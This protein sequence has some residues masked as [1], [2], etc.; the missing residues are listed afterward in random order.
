[1][2]IAQLVCLYEHTKNFKI[3]RPLG[4]ISCLFILLY[5]SCIKYNEINIM[6]PRKHITDRI[7]YEYRSYLFYRAAQNNSNTLV[8]NAK[9]CWI[10]ILCYFMQFLNKF[11][12]KS[13]TRCE[14]IINWAIQNWS[15][16]FLPT[17]SFAHVSLHILS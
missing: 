1:M 17:R 11:N 9:C 6:R 13:T 3:V 7:W 8:T 15:N 12:L 16:P 4:V 5:I 2:N 14:R 10:L